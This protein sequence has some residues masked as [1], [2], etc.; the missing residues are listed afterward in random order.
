MKNWT[1]RHKKTNKAQKALKGAALQG[2]RCPTQRSA[3][4]AALSQHLTLRFEPPQTLPQAF[5]SGREA[6]LRAALSHRGR[7][8]DRR[9]LGT[10]SAQFLVQLE[11]RAELSFTRGRQRSVSGKPTAG[12]GRATAP[13][14]PVTR[15]QGS[16]L[17]TRSPAAPS[18][19][20]EPRPRPAPHQ[21]GPRRRRRVWA[22]RGPSSAARSAPPRSPSPPPRTPP[23][24]PAAAA[25]A[26]SPGPRP[27][28]RAERGERLS[29]RTAA[30]QK[31]SGT[32]GYGARYG[33]N[34]ARRGLPRPHLQPGH[35]AQQSPPLR[36]LL[37]GTRSRRHRLRSNE[38]AVR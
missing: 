32:A 25:A 29:A 19:R 12:L 34:E 16:P 10:R 7:G 24:R 30:R 17:P 36:A 1:D 3:L 18:A 35:R 22:D 8:A 15:P 33:F 20:T 28:G 13:F 5:L 9:E 26:G 23:A 27:A 31:R 38:G 11:L 21:H 4:P 14:P 6:A 2:S 37:P